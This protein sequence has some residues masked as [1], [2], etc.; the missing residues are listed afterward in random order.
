M[1]LKFDYIKKFLKKHE[2]KILNYKYENIQIN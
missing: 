1:L 2:Q